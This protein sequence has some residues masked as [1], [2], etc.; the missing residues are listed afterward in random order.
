MFSH[1]QWNLLCF[2]LCFIA[3]RHGNLYFKRTKKKPTGSILFAASHQIILD[4][5]KI[6]LNLLIRP[7]SPNSLSLFSKERCCSPSIA[8]VALHSTLCSVITSVLT[9]HHAADAGRKGSL[10]SVCWLMSCCS[11]WQVARWLKSPFKARARECEAALLSV[12]GLICLFFPV[13]WPAAGTDVMSLLP[14]LSLILTHKLSVGSLSIL[15]QLLLVIESNMPLSSSHP[16]S[17]WRRSFLLNCKKMI[18]CCNMKPNHLWY[19]KYLYFSDL[20]SFVLY[21][22]LP[23]DLWGFWIQLKN[24]SKKKFYLLS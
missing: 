1:V 9:G 11:V 18:T 7:N 13:R 21:K 17:S 23:E 22:H 10:P 14:V 20:L 24:K 19:R 15:R 16:V 2:S 8:L 5:D 3:S 12:E 4:I 6:S